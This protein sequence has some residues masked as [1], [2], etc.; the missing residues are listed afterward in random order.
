MCNAAFACPGRIAALATALAL[1]AIG[2]VPSADPLPA[3][4]TAAPTPVPPISFPRDAGAH[5]NLTEWWYY[6]GQLKS[7]DGQQAYGFE[8]TIFQVRRQGNPTGYLA[9][10]AVTD[11]TNQRFS[12]QARF[13]VG[14]PRPGL[15]LNV[16]GWRLTNENGIDVIEA[17]MAPGPGAE[18][19]FGL[20]LR[21]RDLKPPA[22]HNGGYIQ[23]GD[24]GGSYY[25][26]RTRIAAEGE[27]RGGDGTWAPVQGQ[28]WM[29]HQWGDFVVATQGGW[30]WYS[31]QFDDNTEL[32]LYV[33]R[34]GKGEESAVYGSEVLADGTV[35]NLEPGAVQTTATG[36]WTSP[37]TGATYPSGWTI[38]LPE[39]S[40]RLTVTPKVKDQELYF[41]GAQMTSP[42]PVYWEGA[43]AISGTRAGAAVTGEGYVELTGY[44]P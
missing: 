32:M 40:L 36:R 16:E 42:V 6:T 3:A 2:C 11:V 24:A 44:A 15:N 4:P 5:D 13:T 27:I 38:D 37:H 41:P 23:Y 8:F 28:A 9:N 1:I 31:L 10:F 20:R 30:D 33:L 14:E 34:N 35:R 12:H 26:S 21:L 19:A 25:Y 22:L 18:P 43:V 17:Q 7:A 29:D 39:R